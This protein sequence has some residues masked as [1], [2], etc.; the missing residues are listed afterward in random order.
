M[1]KKYKINIFSILR[2]SKRESFWTN[3]YTA[4][5]A[6]SIHSR[7]ILICLLVVFRRCFILHF[8]LQ[9]GHAPARLL[10][11]EHK[12]RRC[13]PS[14]RAATK[15]RSTVH[16]ATLALSLTLGLTLNALPGPWTG[17]A[18]GYVTVNEPLPKL[19]GFP[20]GADQ[21]VYPGTVYQK[22]NLAH[23]FMTTYSDWS[24]LDG[25]DAIKG[26]IRNAV[27]AQN[28][29]SGELIVISYVREPLW[30]TVP[31]RSTIQSI[32]LTGN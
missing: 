31:I 27:N 1:S 3:G 10:Q 26:Q 30:L 25:S 11:R 21:Y 20:F 9:E 2:S 6:P 7:L 12:M 13:L 32:S 22:P 23:Q 28:D 24:Y 4:T 16:A 14:A 15:S 17:A 29:N 5:L 19:G 8:W 18:L